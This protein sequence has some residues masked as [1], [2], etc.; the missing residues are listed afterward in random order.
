[1]DNE[2]AKEHPMHH[3]PLASR[4]ITVAFA[5]AGWLALTATADAQSTSVGLSTVRA[6][7]FG[8]DNLTGVFTPEAGDQFAYSL[9]AG[10]FDGDGADDLATGMPYDNGLASRPVNDSG[11]VVVRYSTPGSGLT[12]D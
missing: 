1:M 8:N 5:A 3:V 6:Q 7:R 11:S 2:P 9:A 12:T 4:F 10:D